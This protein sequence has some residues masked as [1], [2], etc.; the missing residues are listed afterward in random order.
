[1]EPLS[2]S[3]PTFPPIPHPNSPLRSIWPTHR[4][5]SMPS[6]FKTA[7]TWLEVTCAP[8]TPV[9]AMTPR[10]L[11]PSTCSSIAELV[12]RK[13]G[14]VCVRVCIYEGRERERAGVCAYTNI[15]RHFFAIYLPLLLFR[16]MTARLTFGRPHT[17][18]FFLGT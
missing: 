2:R 1:M 4:A 10:I 16:V 8:F 15:K 13:G 12:Q 9:V 7:I 3:K 14:L 11:V 6:V 18:T 17:T 5:A